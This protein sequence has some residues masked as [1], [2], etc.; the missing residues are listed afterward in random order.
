MKLISPSMDYIQSYRNYIVELGDEERYPFPLDFDHADFPAMLS[1]LE[2]FR[3]GVDLPDGYVASST[4]WLVDGEELLGVSNLRHY[5]N[6]RIAHAGGHIGLGIRP[7]FR[8]RG[9]GATL[10]RLTLGKAA[11]MNIAPVQVHCY[12]DNVGSKAM[13]EQC[14]GKLDST[15]V[16]GHHRVLRY[17]F[18]A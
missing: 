11:E 3:L 17:R 6:E 5:L 16:T 7:S 14:G 12:A 8:Q 10:L 9:L 18:D 2:Q 15:V 1:R 13:I 4:Y